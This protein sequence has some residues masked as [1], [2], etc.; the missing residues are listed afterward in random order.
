MCSMDVPLAGWWGNRVRVEVS[1]VG[2][3][4]EA[5]CARWRHLQSLTPDFGSPLVGPDFAKLIARHRGD[6]KVAVGYRGGEAIA[7][8]AF[9]A[10]ARGYVRAIGAPFCDYQAI[11]SDPAEPVNGN[12]FLAQAG[13]SSLVCTSLMDPHGLFANQTLETVDSY[14]IDCIHGSSNFMESLRAANPKW[15]KNLRRLGNKMDRELGAMRLVGHDRAQAGFDALMDIKI[16]QFHETGMTNV[17]RPAWVMGFMNELFANQD[18]EF[19]GCLVSL[20]AGEKFVAGQFGVR[21]GD[22]FHPWIASTCPASHPY[23]PGIVFLAEM[24]KEADALGLRV[25]DLSEGHGHYKAQFCRTPY[26]AKAGIVGVD[27][28]TAPSRAKGVV[29]L[30][31][32][33]FDLISAV[34]PDFGGRIVA[35]GNAVA[36]VPRRL[37]ARMD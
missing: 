32:R 31:N 2:D 3:L 28:A 34:E 35:L 8:M 11:V 30:I 23:S 36:S 18:G 24:L 26:K 12:D 9:H 10:A 22:W 29:G 37:I 33:R 15:A 25:I 6:G 21:L 1:D 7:F 17:L 27:P 5:L 20:Y 13:I 19:G 16:R 14:R 4:G